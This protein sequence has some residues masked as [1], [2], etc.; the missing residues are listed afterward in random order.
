MKGF[1]QKQRVGSK[2]IHETLI[3]VN[4][5]FKVVTIPEINRRVKEIFH[6]ESEMTLEYFEIADETTLKGTDFFYKDKNYR[7]FIVVFVGDVR[8]IDNFHLE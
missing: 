3:K 7:A 4:D 8:L 1:R 6:K 5:W 2:I